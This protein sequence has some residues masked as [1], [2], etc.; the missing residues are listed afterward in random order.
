MFLRDNTVEDFYM[1]TTFKGWQEFVIFKKKKK[2]FI[3]D[4]CLLTSWIY[5]LIKKREEGRKETNHWVSVTLNDPRT[6]YMWSHSVLTSNLWSKYWHLF[7]IKT[8]RFIVYL[9]ISPRLPCWSWL[10]EIGLSANET[11]ALYQ[12]FYL[13]ILKHFGGS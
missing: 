1:N 2:K 13:F 3:K 5:K 8:L 4:L 11:W 9:V 7:E 10:T 6:F 12:C